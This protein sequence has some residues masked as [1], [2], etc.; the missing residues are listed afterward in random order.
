MLDVRYVCGSFTQPNCCQVEIMVMVRLLLL[1]GAFLVVTLALYTCVTC[2]FVILAS[3]YTYA[4][5]LSLQQNGVYTVVITSGCVDLHNA[6]APHT[7]SGAELWLL[8]LIHEQ[9]LVRIVQQH[10]ALACSKQ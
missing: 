7:V 3:A 2:F 6:H 1:H 9:L 4:G 8:S 10:N 5:P